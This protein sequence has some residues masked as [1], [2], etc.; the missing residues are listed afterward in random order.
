MS[1][2]IPEISKIGWNFDNSYARLPE[3]MLSRLAPVSVQVPKLIIAKVLR[4]TVTGGASD[5]FATTAEA[6]CYFDHYN[7][8]DNMWAYD[9]YLYRIDNAGGATVISK[10]ALT[11]FDADGFTITKSKSGSPTGNI[12]VMYTCIG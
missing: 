12:A 11:S 1:E 7:G 9:N 10:A 2:I 4:N 3:M 5:G 8:N 6:K